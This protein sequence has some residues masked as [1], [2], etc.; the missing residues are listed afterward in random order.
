V[1]VMV[2]HA[3]GWKGARANGVSHLT[4][5]PEPD[6]LM[7]AST[8]ELLGRRP[9]P[10]IDKTEQRAML[11]TELVQMGAM[12]KS[13]C[14]AEAWTDMSS[15]KRLDPHRV[16][17][18]HLD[19]YV[20][21]P[22][23]APESTLVR[24]LKKQPYYADQVLTQINAEGK[25]LAEAVILAD[26]QEGDVRIQL[27]KGRLR[28]NR[29]AAEAQ[30]FVDDTPCGVPDEVV[31]I[32]SVSFKELLSSIPTDPSWYCCHWWGEP[33]LDFNKCCVEHA[34]RRS[35]TGKESSYWVCGYA[36]RQHELKTEIS[37]DPEKS[38][39]RKAMSIACGVML[40]LDSSAIPFQRIWCDYELFITLS[41][42]EKL[43]DI[44]TVSDHRVHLLTDGAVPGEEFLDKTNRERSFPV[45]LLAK[46]LD[47]ELQEGHSSVDQD[48]QNILKAIGSF[49]SEFSI[50]GVFDERM[51]AKNIDLANRSL[52]ARLALC[53]WPQAVKRGIVRKF[54]S[55]AASGPCN[56]A[57]ILAAD[58]ERT[59]VKLSFAGIKASDVDIELVSSGLP[60]NLKALSLSF[61]SCDKI[62]D[63]GLA[64]LAKAL[65]SKGSL[66]HLHLDFLG[67][68]L[69]TD[70]G[71]EFLVGKFPPMIHDIN[72]NFA[73]C[74]ELTK[75]SV[76]AVDSCIPSKN[77]KVRAD[78]T[79]TDVDEVF[80]SAKELHQACA[81]GFLAGIK[82]L[83][84]K[85]TKIA[86]SR[87]SVM[88]GKGIGSHHTSAHD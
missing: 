21:S 65:Q 13:L 32:D 47:V 1:E 56:L 60:R 11:L 68:I 82:Q 39:F 83:T 67:C 69:L 3:S 78:F 43:L 50:Q 38:S 16:N 61:E 46:G 5:W 64:L 88:T 10:C 52:R 85:K 12:V 27:L 7:H 49:E 70:T 72:L 42:H 84:K 79:G 17:L 37:N 80:E 6:V 66:E 48:K 2:G 87:E 77:T 20:I 44:A 28:C 45:A 40:V 14:T 54:P 9:V 8:A 41:H 25:I 34:N 71:V 36:N 22:R 62:T 4:H 29:T 19:Y 75:A 74:D 30:V 26:E 24:G 57:S 73:L 63:R 81:R 35:L 51:L 86:L 76:R 55:T 15:G 58:V 59:S 31:N 33:I 53:A 23:T 18:Y